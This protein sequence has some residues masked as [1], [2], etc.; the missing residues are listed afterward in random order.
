MGIFA[1][2]PFVT[3][4][5]SLVNVCFQSGEKIVSLSLDD[6]AGRMNRL[7]R[8]S[9]ELHRKPDEDS[10]GVEIVTHE[11]FHNAGIG[12]T[13]GGIVPATNENLTLALVWMNRMAWGFDA[14]GEI[15]GERAIR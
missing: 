12:P 9:I 3:Q 14:Q 8:G 4:N 7:S 2:H 13:G 1:H 15:P 10:D 11:V 5:G 6:S